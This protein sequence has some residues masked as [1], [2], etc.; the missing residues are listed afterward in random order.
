M[1]FFQAL[2]GSCG[3]K[4]IFFS[5]A[6]E[7]VCFAIEA[8]FATGF[9]VLLAGVVALYVCY[10]VTLIAAKRALSKKEAQSEW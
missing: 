3:C 7:L 10:I 5:L 8:E 4:L 6:T 1:A 2:F 9:W